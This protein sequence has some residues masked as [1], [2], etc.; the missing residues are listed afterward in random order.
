MIEKLSIGGNMNI[1][2]QAKHDAVVDATAKLF[3]ERSIAEVTIKDIADHIG[4]GEATVY[5]HFQNKANLVASSANYL[6]KIVLTKFFDLSGAKTGYEKLELFYNS[7]VNIFRERN[8]YF[9]FI[10]ELDAY[11]LNNPDANGVYEDGVA[12]FKNIWD[13]A[14]EL[15]QKDGSLRT[16][17]D[18][19]EF[20]YA[21]THS[22]LELCKKLSGK[23]VI[24]QDYDV[25][26]EKEIRTL[27]SI[28]LYRIKENVFLGG[29][30]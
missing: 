2:E 26:K 8:E 22:L 15:G 5:R 16:L 6:S 30:R 18:K 10:K 24:R 19:D 13:E 28:F 12:N 25:N 11:L 27:I 17:P 20:Y 9:K 1:I 29:I 7:Y 21:T 14:Y 3:M 4:I 23:E